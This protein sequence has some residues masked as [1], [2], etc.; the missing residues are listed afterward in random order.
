MLVDGSDMKEKRLWGVMTLIFRRQEEERKTVS[1][2]RSRS[3][4]EKDVGEIRT[5]FRYEERK[6]KLRRRAR[7]QM[8]F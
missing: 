2:I 5:D 7:Q 8:I 4:G 6:K 1:F 3:I